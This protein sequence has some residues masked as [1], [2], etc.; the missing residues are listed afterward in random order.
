MI[1]YL[2]YSALTLA[3]REFERY[4]LTIYSVLIFILAK[5]F[6]VKGNCGK[7]RLSFTIP[8]WMYDGHRK[9]LVARL[10]SWNKAHV[11]IT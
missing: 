6:R 3:A 11:G 1:M 5:R 4:L 9:L 7:A 8:R 2:R 10:V